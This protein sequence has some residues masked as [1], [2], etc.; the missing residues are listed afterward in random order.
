MTTTDD[1]TTLVDNSANAYN[2]FTHI[3]NFLWIPGEH[4]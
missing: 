3:A 1:M 2:E 4:H